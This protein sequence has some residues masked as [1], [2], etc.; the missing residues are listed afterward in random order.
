M[1]EK[2]AVTFKKK[3]SF[4]P[5]Y[6]PL[7]FQR[8]PTYTNMLN[9]DSKCFP[10]F[11]SLNFSS[12][13]SNQVLKSLCVFS[14]YALYSSKNLFESS[15]GFSSHLFYLLYS[16]IIY[17]LLQFTN[18]LQ[19]RHFE[20]LVKYLLSSSVSYSCYSKFILWSYV[21]QVSCRPFAY[22]LV[23]CTLKGRQ[24]IQSSQAFHKS[25]CSNKIYEFVCFWSFRTYWSVA[26]FR[27]VW[28]LL[29]L[30]NC[31]NTSYC[32]PFRDIFVGKAIFQSGYNLYFDEHMQ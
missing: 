20:F 21:F 14:V 19:R 24:A 32:L 4:L 18:L 28:D 3:I 17:I 2:F 25:L 15:L 23:C 12:L 11:T 22:A 7:F 16:C 31:A 5:I 13:C 10:L 8:L 27:N 9:D 6:F 29:F 30:Y 26:Y 1:F